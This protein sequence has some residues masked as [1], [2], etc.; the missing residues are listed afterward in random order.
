[1]LTKL[2][3]IISM[4]AIVVLILLNSGQGLAEEALDL[5]AYKQKMKEWQDLKYGLFVHWGPCSIAGV[6][7]GWGRKAPRQGVSSTWYPTDAI[8]GEEYDNLHKEFDPV[9]FDAEAWIKTGKKAG[10]KYIV[11]TAK[12]VDGFM[13]WDT[14]T[15]DYNIMNTPYGKDICKEIADACHKQ[16]IKLGWYYAPCDWYDLDCRNSDPQR[17]AVY[18]K[19]MKQQLREL[20]TNYGKVDILW[21]DTD[22]GSALYDQDNT[23][24]MIRRLQP[25]I[26]INNRME[27]NRLGRDAGLGGWADSYHKRISGEPARWKDFGDYDASAE[28]HIG[29]WNTVPHESC[30][31][32]IHGQ[33]AWKPNAVLYSATE[34]ANL[35]VQSLVNN[36]NFLYN[37]GPMPTGEIEDRQQ[38]RLLK[39]GAWLEKVGEAVYGTRGGPIPGGQWG[40][41]T[42][43]GKNVY[44]FLPD[45]T[46]NDW[47]K[48][49]PYPLT[50]LNK[51]LV[52]AESLTGEKVSA[53]QNSDGLIE[54]SLPKA[55]NKR[56]NGQAE[57]MIVKLTFD[58]ANPQMK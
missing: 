38:D 52:A 1:M 13:L 3:C 34:G 36:G 27:F 18:V 32:M 2:R 19:R 14:K 35:L 33:W 22:G 48:D 39:T 50:P 5:N 16:G 4:F 6:E 28:N 40:G 56:Q 10:M 24:A 8:P 53:V 58:E 46:V 51:N 43:N 7:I 41:T 23:Y 47:P 29:G 15:S 31:S 37:I 45:N 57:F 17:H 44:L 9:D 26:V 25:E 55:T 12:H 49:K 42:T 20:M 21:F 11:S 30:K 54:I